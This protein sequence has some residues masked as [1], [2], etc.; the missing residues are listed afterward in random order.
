MAP[1]LYQNQNQRNN[2]VVGSESPGKEATKSL[3]A[4]EITA[5][6]SNVEG[7]GGKELCAILRTSKAPLRIVNQHAS[8]MA[9]DGCWQWHRIGL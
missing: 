1:E 2:R 3:L 8:I 7:W 5:D 9:T 4:T 6:P